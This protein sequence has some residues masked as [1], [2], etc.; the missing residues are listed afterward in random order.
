[1]SSSNRKFR[2]S[3][4]R[5]PYKKKVQKQLDEE[6]LQ[7][8]QEAF[9]LFDQD[10]SGTIDVQEL[11]AAMRALGFNVQDEEIKRMISD[12]DKDGNMEIDFNEFKNMMTGRMTSRD[13]K[14]EIMKVFRLFCDEGSDFIT[15]RNLKEVCQDLGENLTDENIR[16]NKKNFIQYIY[17]TKI[18]IKTL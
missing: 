1:M 2:M 4:F 13:S 16:V 9:E 5:S 10:G 7:E 18:H 14:D 12:V 6:Q 11:K 17:N 8:L 15:Y 3:R